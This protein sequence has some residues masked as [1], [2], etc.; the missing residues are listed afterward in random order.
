MKKKSHYRITARLLEKMK[1]ATKKKA[2]LIGS[3]MPDFLLYTFKRG[4]YY[5]TTEKKVLSSLASLRNK[6]KWA[7]ADYYRFGYQIH[8]IED[9]FT[10]VHNFSFLKN[11]KAHYAY[12]VKLQKQIPSFFRENLPFS[13]SP[14]PFEDFL[15][16]THRTYLSLPN[17]ITTDLF[18]IVTVVRQ[19]LYSFRE[20]L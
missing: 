9:Y 12:E 6:R 11:A 20:K 14:L 1:C 19:L 16:S 15:R 4:H 18:Y 8:F 17:S 2:I 3:V 7:L 5:D 13:P 10:Y